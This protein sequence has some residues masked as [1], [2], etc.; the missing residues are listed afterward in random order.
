MRSLL[1]KGGRWLGERPLVISLWS[2]VWRGYLDPDDRV[3]YVIGWRSARVSGRQLRWARVTI[4]PLLSWQ[5]KRK[6]K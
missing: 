5:H 1:L 6:L 4:C 2:W 3:H